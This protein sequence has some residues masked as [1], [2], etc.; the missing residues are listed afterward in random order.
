M[1]KALYVLALSMFLLVGTNVSAMT[2]AIPSAIGPA[3]NTPCTPK[4]F[5]NIIIAGINKTI[6]LDID[7]IALFKL[8]PIAWKNIPDGIWTPLNI[9]NIKYVLN[10][11]QANSM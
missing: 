2:N 6:C 8:F 4:M 3:D 1:K 5:P 7:N 9:H 10:A 11:K